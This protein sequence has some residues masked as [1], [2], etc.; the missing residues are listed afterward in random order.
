[1]DYQVKALYDVNEVFGPYSPI[2]NG[3][4]ELLNLPKVAKGGLAKPKSHKYDHCCSFMMA[5]P[6]TNGTVFQPIT[7]RWT[8][9]DEE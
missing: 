1:M 4:Q 6:I 7:I 2:Q 3:R 8:S 9:E 5:F